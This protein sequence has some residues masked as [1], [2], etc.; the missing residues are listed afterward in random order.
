MLKSVA[1]RKISEEYQSRTFGGV[2]AEKNHDQ[3]PLGL[4]I[5]EK[6]RHLSA[7]SIYREKSRLQAPKFQKNGVWEVIFF[8][9][10]KI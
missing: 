10:E 3:S 1:G 2:Y 5:Q 9:I 4:E 8:C 6:F 7:Y